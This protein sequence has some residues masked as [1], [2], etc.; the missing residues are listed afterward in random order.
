MLA[1]R[2]LLELE[3]AEEYSD[4]LE[5]ELAKE[6]ENGRLFRLLVKLDLL[7]LSADPSSW[8]EVRTPFAAAIICPFPIGSEWER[9]KSTDR[10]GH[11]DQL[12]GG[13]QHALRLFREHV[14]QQVGES[15]APM[16]DFGHVV[17][18]LN[19]LDLGTEERVALVTRDNAT[20][21]V[22]AYKELKLASDAAFKQLLSA[23]PAPSG[24]PM[25]AS[26]HSTVASAATAAALPYVGA[27]HGS[28]PFSPASSFAAAASLHLVAPSNNNT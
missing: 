7:D 21:L 16:L 20:V 12:Q 2:I 14:F 27:R 15:G 4:A 1:P 6:L 8:Q 24:A 26:L 17:E 10:N 22:A 11:D 25:S 9:Q 19:K 28:R 13:E 3:Q 18:C 23:K 5:T